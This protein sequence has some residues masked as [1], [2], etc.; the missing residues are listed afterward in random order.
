M[1]LTLMIYLRTWNSQLTMKTMRMSTLSLKKRIKLSSTHLKIKTS[2]EYLTFYWIFWA[3]RWN[4][5]RIIV[6]KL[7]PRL[8]LLALLLTAH[9]K[10]VNWLIMEWLL[11]GIGTQEI[12]KRNSAFITLEY[13]LLSSWRIFSRP[14]R[15]SK[16]DLKKDRIKR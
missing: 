8:L 14:L 9:T 11:W 1:T 2:R 6:I 13:S 16:K 15:Y 10:N 4:N 7:L 12:W 5:C 3:T